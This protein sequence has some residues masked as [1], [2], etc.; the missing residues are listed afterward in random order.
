MSFDYI[1]DTFGEYIETTPRYREV[2]NKAIR[3]LMRIAR[4]EISHDAIYEGFEEV[5]KTMLELDDHVIRPGDPLWLTQFLTFHYF[6]WRDWY[7]LNKIYT[8]Q[9]ERFNTE[10]LQA[11]YHEI[12][13]MEHDQGFF[14]ICRTCLEELSHKVKLLEKEGV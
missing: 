12:S 14:N 9:P 7:I 2:E 4:D 3:L 5:R 1:Y 6:K 13:Q 8:E 10:E 11:R